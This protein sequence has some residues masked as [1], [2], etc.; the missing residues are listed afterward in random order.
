[1]VH[2]ASLSAEGEHTI[3]V[4]SRAGLD[5]VRLF[6]P[7]HGL[8]GRAAAGEEHDRL[9]ATWR[10]Y[11]DDDLDAYADARSTETPVVVLE[12]RAV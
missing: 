7:E 5:V 6:S 11:G 8:R 9:W 10:D 2:A 1:M 3:D 4:L 12:P